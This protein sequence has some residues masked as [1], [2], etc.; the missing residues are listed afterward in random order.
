MNVSRLMNVKRRF[1]GFALWVAFGEIQASRR[2]PA[3]RASLR[4][5]WQRV[6]CATGTLS[7]V[8]PGAACRP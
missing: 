4:W 5:L 8:R 6:G 3:G 1:E 2:Q 7:K